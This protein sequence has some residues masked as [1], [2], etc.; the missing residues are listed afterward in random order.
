MS[1]VSKHAKLLIT[2]VCCLALG[3]GASAI[4]TAGASTSSHAGASRAQARL[5][6]ARAGV[7]RR[8]ARRTVH[9]NLV[10]ATRTGFA[11]VTLDRGKVDSVSGRQLTLTEGTKANSYKTL[12]LT[13][14]PG[15]RIRDN[16]QLAAMSAIKPGQRVI[17][18]Q[19]PRRTFVF[20]HT[21]RSG[22]GF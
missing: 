18:L 22:G 5:A 21:P 2:A 11:N 15:A 1:F 19:A 13:I 17:V 12:T 8:L 3:A 4:A 10:V 7:L 9:A 16:R 6:G 14:P 20:A